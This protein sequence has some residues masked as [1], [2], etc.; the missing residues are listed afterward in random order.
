MQSNDANGKPISMTVVTCIESGIL[1]PL[2]LRMVDSLR[3]FGGRFANLEVVAVTPRTTPPLANETLKGMANLG[4]RHLRVHPNNPYAWH[5]FMNKTEAIVAVEKEVSTEAIA[6]VD[7]DIIFMREPVHLELPPGIDFLASAPDTGMVGSTGM[8]D[9]NDLFWQR[10]AALIGKN[11]DEL[12]WLDTGD[13]QRIRFYWNA[14]LDVYRRATH[15]GAEF[16]SDFRRFLDRRIARTHYQVHA[17]DQVVLG[18]TVIRL[19]L[20]WK[21]LPVSSN[22]PVCSFLPDN[23]DP[24]RVT[25]VSILHFHDSMN[26]ELWPRLLHTIAPAHPR[27]HAWLAPQGPVV[28]PS[29]TFSE[30]AREALR[31]TR[32]MYRRAYYWRSGFTKTLR[33][34]EAPTQTVA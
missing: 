7:S 26:Q 22:F 23:Y 2:T 18:L 1:E 27:I 3:R 11:V 30:I 19:G 28:A 10:C 32:G 33:G 29:T 12:P 14:G 13:G 6:W 31:L 20:A 24:S 4:I 21:A 8:N 9:P 15:F 25:D 34:E 17:M 16:M 5:H